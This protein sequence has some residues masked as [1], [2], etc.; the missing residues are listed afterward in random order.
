M[1][2]R[3]K[4]NNKLFRRSSYLTVDNLI[5]WCSELEFGYILP[6]NIFMLFRIRFNC[7]SQNFGLGAKRPIIKKSY[8]HNDPLANG[9]MLVETK[10]IYFKIP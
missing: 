7:F 6:C 10:L 9:S 3:R 4:K 5:T 8:S 2:R 1:Q